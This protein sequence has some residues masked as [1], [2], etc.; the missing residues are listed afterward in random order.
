MIVS[1][2]LNK[3]QLIRAQQRV[4]TAPKEQ[5]DTKA[6][7]CGNLLGYQEDHGFSWNGDQHLN[8]DGDVVTYTGQRCPMWQDGS[9]AILWEIATGDAKEYYSYALENRGQWDKD[10][11]ESLSTLKVVKYET[12][13]ARLEWI[14][15]LDL[16]LNT[17]GTIDD[18]LNVVEKEQWRMLGRGWWDLLSKRFSIPDF[19][20]MD[21]K[22]AHA[23]YNKEEIA[24]YTR[25]TKLKAKFLSPD[26]TG[27]YTSL[28]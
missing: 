12:S 3:E 9:A 14:D 15:T 8:L 22:K 21:A 10:C 25:I 27:E 24:L 20:K 26:I 11:R 4:Q 28:R 2:K 6:F 7:Y 16:Y 5:E 18:I 23:Q 19:E 1:F 17:K 13:D